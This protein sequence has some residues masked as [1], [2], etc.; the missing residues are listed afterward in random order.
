MSRP[1]RV[2]GTVVGATLLG[3][4]GGLALSRQRHHA[5]RQELFDPRAWRRLAALG[6][7]ERHGDAGAL[8]LLRDYLAWE[9]RPTLAARAARVVRALELSA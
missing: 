9:P 7:I 8:P 2:V 1:A 4:A 3:L 6:W 5:N